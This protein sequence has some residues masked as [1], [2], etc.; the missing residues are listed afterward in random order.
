MSGFGSGP[1]GGG[2]F[3]GGF[4]ANNN[5]FGGG[6]Q[7]QPP[8]GGSNSQPQQQQPSF[9]YKSNPFGNSGFS[10][11]AP[12]FG[13]PPNASTFGQ[14]TGGVI[15]FGSSPNV[16]QQFGAQGFS[17]G[18]VGQSST[19]GQS[20]TSSGFGS[21]SFAAPTSTFPF[22]AAPPTSQNNNL[23]GS[24]TATNQVMY[25][26]GGAGLAQASSN[27][28]GNTAPTVTFGM[29]SNVVAETHDDSEMSQSPTPYGN[30]APN[31]GMQDPHDGAPSVFGT[32]ST[33]IEVTAVQT[34]WPS[35]SSGPFGGGNSSRNNQRQGLGGL[36]PIPE[37]ADDTTGQEEGDSDKLAELKA[38]IEEKK[39]KLLEQKRR[40]ETLAA[41]HRTGTPDLA[42]RNAVRFGSNNNNNASETTRA[43]LPADIVQNESSTAVSSNIRSSIPGGAPSEREHLSEAVSLVGTCMYMCPDE[44][45]LRR[46]REGDIQLL[47]IP[48][49]GELHP[50]SWTLRDTVVKRFR[51]SAADFKLDVPEWVRPPD[52]LEK[53]VGY[54]EEWVMVRMAPNDC[55]EFVETLTR[56]IAMVGTRSPGARLSLSEQ[57][58]A[59][60]FGRVSVYLGSNKNGSKRLC[61]AEL[62]WDGRELRRSSCPLPRAHGEV[63][64]HVRTPAESY[65]GFCDDAESAE[66]SRAWTNN[67]NPEPVL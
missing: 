32:P 42:Q 22:G 26:G 12:T 5:P 65:P 40:K 66:H 49:P 27:P 47:E 39:R 23:F 63:A 16:V 62:H 20:P 7:Q 29:S 2:G 51:R 59:S 28:F 50:P 58:D 34:P 46:Q 30:F 1:G 17:T 61:V 19:F 56:L 8:F 3:G 36:S 37:S 44:E 18:V 48:R 15:N 64:C 9:G 55:L 25:G 57:W 35:K 41:S 43:H 54:L 45:L 21:T 31:H 67:E 60:A 14:T 4:G 53:V 6:Q 11:A 24:N 33:N 52:V 13:S 38:R 10:A